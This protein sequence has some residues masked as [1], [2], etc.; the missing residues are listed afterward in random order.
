MNKFIK[1]CLSIVGILMAFGLVLFV[2]GAMF[3]GVH[4]VVD[5]TRR[6]GFNYTFAN[7]I[8]HV[9]ALDWD[10]DDYDEYYEDL[11]EYKE[12]EFDDLGEAD[13][14]DELK[15]D[16]GACRLEVEEHDKDTYQVEVKNVYHLQCMNR[17]GVLVIGGEKDTFPNFGER[18]VTVYVPKGEKLDSLDISL[19]AGSGRVESVNAQDISIEVGA[20][21]LTGS[22][23]TAE[24]AGISVGAGSVVFHDCEFKESKF[25]V[26]VGSAVYKG[27]LT[28]D[29]DIDC[30]MGNVT[31]K[32]AGEREDFNYDMECD[33]GRIEVDRLQYSG[34]GNHRREDNDA[35][36]TMDLDCA[37]G[38]IT[39]RFED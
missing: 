33:M 18:R 17:D 27:E 35:S 24:D 12:Y 32:L 25:D 19:G 39:V 21:E 26:G 20:G 15:I 34:M 4:Q 2:I 23:L 8:V 16:I 36:K 6:G 13:E 30:G 11:E 9:N 29:A 31:M 3:G 14:I 5:I 37:M 38:N 22:N 1:V 28:G 7:G 10:M